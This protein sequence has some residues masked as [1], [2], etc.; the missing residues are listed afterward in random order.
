[1]ARLKLSLGRRICDLRMIRR[2]TQVEFA[3]RAGLSEDG[4]KDIEQGRSCDPR[5]CSLLKIVDAL[6]IT[7]DE[8]L[9]EPEA[10]GW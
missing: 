4:L 2:L 5:L 10:P 1:M 6:G 3:E 9:T 8:L 7:L